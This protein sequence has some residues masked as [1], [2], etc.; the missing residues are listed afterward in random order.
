MIVAKEL[1]RDR[2]AKRIA[3]EFEQT[4]KTLIVNLG[5][6]LP[7]KV[8]DFIKKTNV[9]FQ[10]ENGMLGVG[11]KAT[12]G[13]HDPLLINAGREYVTELPGTSFFDSASSFA[14]IRGGHVDAT[15]IGAFEVD[16][17]GTIANW[18]IPNG[19]WLG[20]GG[21]MD[22]VT[23][24]RQVIVSMTHTSRDGKPKLV[25][26]CSLPIT[27][28]QEVDMIVTELAVFVFEDRKMILKEIAPEVDLK[29][30]VKITGPAF[31]V[32]PS[33]CQYKTVTD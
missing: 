5:V 26:E 29:S 11:P 10:S 2:I 15:V 19:K 8:A 7:T 28:Y 12:E 3:H 21:A 17:Q 6:G 13:N 33:L 27:G 16:G 23:G 14:M 1:V 20:V 30:L 24:A 25:T 18:I 4:E 9:Y 32:S 22:L 31:D